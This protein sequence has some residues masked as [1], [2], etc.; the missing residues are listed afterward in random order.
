MLSWPSTI[1]WTTPF[2]VF[3]FDFFSVGVFLSRS[4]SLRQKRL[5]GRVWEI[6]V[7]NLTLCGD[8]D[9]SALSCLNSTY[10][11]MWKHYH[12]QVLLWTPSERQVKRMSSLL[13]FLAAMDKALDPACCLHGRLLVRVW[14]CLGSV[15][16]ETSFPSTRGSQR[17]RGFL[18]SKRFPIGSEWR[19]ELGRPPSGRIGSSTTFP[20]IHSSRTKSGN[21]CSRDHGRITVIVVLEARALVR[22]VQAL[23]SRH[24]LSAL[25]PFVAI[26][27]DMATCLALGRLRSKGKHN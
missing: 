6:L 21:P 13:F 27:D 5:P 26:V 12:D 17:S 20:Q 24:V 11:F 3:F 10:P 1:D 4:F 18:W 16:S 15:P 2:W 25:S 22:G 14:S 8:L 9:L 23:F 19:W 7:G